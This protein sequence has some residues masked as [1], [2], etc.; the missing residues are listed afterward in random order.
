L[1]K[2]E[3]TNNN[4]NN[5]KKQIEI[6]NC[7]GFSQLYAQPV[8]SITILLNA[9]ELKNKLCAQEQCGYQ[10]DVSESQPA[11]CQVKTTIRLIAAG[12]CR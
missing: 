11:A 3:C 8:D 5:L 6:N 9:W 7:F 1:A 2:V 4:N 10:D 12:I